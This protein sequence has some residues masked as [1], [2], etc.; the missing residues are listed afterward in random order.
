[1]LQN[2]I[3]DTSGLPGGETAAAA[4]HSGVQVE[5]RLQNILRIAKESGAS[6]VH[7]TVAVPPV[8]RVNNQLVPIPGEAKL[9]PADTKNLLFP[10]I[11][12]DHRRT[13]TESGEVDFSFGIPSIGR[14]RVNVYRQR[15][16]YAAAIRIM[17]T[18]IPEPE[19]LGLPAS[20]IDLYRKQS[21]LVLVTG[22]TGSGKSTTLASIIQKINE[23]RSCHI[24]TLE[25]PIEYLYRHDKS[26]VDQREI[27]LDSRSFAAALRAALREDPDV[28]LVGEMR[29]LE[30][31]STAIT[32]A[33]TGH[34]VFSTLHTIGAASTINRI[35]DVFPEGQKEQIRTQLSMVMESVISQRLIPRTD[36]EGRTACFEVMHCTPAIRALIRDDKTYQIPSIIQTNR[37]LGMITMDDALLE[38]YR[39]HLISP[40]DAIEYA[41]DSVSMQTRMRSS[42]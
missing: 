7:I 16:S 40:Q 19:S 2:D 12:E 35:V 28:I 17:S 18:S 5:P 1:M 13:L 34:L 32:A 27:G 38:A 21:G 23:N 9:L 10:T 20:V 29:D 41:T 24:L 25:D 15:G 39:N 6:D 14:F 8:M 26:L 3:E 4:K 31:I 36:G 22:P 37:R 30:T 42:Y 11:D 33:E